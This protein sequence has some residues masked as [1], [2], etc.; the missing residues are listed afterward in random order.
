ME[1]HDIVSLMRE[2]K[3][4]GM[5]AAYDDVMRA[6]I[7]HQRSPAEILGD[8]LNAELAEKTARSI[9]YQMSAALSSSAKCNT[10]CSVW[11]RVGCKDLKECCHGIV[12]PSFA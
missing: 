12:P 5:R 10:P 4:A 2:L 1:R 11:Y 8:L 7:Q 9:R 6:G 3:L